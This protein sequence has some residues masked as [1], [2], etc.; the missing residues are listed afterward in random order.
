[1]SFIEHVQLMARYNGW[2]NAKVHDTAGKLTPAQLMEDRGAFFKS[3]LG[4]LNHLIVSDISWARRLSGHPK[5]QCFG[6]AADLPTP[7][8]LNDLL[9][10]D[11][12]G[13]RVARDQLDTGFVEFASALAPAD[14]DVI[15]RF[16]RLTGET[17]AKS[18]QSILTHL[19]NHQTHHRGQVTTLLSQFGLDVGVTDVFVLT[20]NPD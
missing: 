7:T 12:H 13:W 11:L 8:A 6:F 18:T 1:M 10:T 2:M 14:L 5:G 17:V 15:I 16:Q 19:F 20:P 9:Y 3:V 4:T